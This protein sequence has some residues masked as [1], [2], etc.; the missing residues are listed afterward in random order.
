[1]ERV[2]FQRGIFTPLL[3]MSGSSRDIPGDPRNSSDISQR[4]EA[5]RMSQSVWSF[6]I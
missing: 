4:L 2:D 6:D 1:M 3:A 5:Q